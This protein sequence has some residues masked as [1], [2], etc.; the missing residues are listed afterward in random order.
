M[1]EYQYQPQNTLNDDSS[2]VTSSFL[3]RA[4]P[5]LIKWQLDPT[6]IIEQLQ[7]QLRNEIWD[8]SKGKYVSVCEPLCNEQGVHSI[9]LHLTSVSKLSMMSDLTEEEING[10]MRK[11]ISDFIQLLFMEYDKWGIEKPYLSTVVNL[12][13]MTLY[14][15]LKRAQNGGERRFLTK[16]ER[17][18]EQHTVNNNTTDQNKKGFF[19]NIFKV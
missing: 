10:I 6:D 9:I 18:V 11:F 2:I 12:V 14:P 17:R 16:T 1:D 3:D 7:H 5:D 15:T 4:T 13:E 8:E 19:S